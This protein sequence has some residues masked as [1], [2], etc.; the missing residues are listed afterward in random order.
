MEFEGMQIVINARETSVD[1]KAAR[2]MGVRTGTGE[3]KIVQCSV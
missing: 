2:W 1:E 3:I